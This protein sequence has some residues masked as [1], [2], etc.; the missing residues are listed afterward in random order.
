VTGVSSEPG[1]VTPPADLCPGFDSIAGPC[2]HGRGHPPILDSSGDS[3]AHATNTGVYWNDPEAADPGDVVRQIQRAAAADERGP[4]VPQ[5]GAETLPLLPADAPP[6]EVVASRDFALWRGGYYRRPPDFPTPRLAPAPLDAVREYLDHAPTPARVEL[7]QLA[8]AGVDRD[9]YA[10]A[11]NAAT[12]ATAPGHVLLSDRERIVRAALLEAA[13]RLRQAWQ[14]AD[15]TEAEH[16]QGLPT[17]ERDLMG[18]TLPGRDDLVRTRQEVTKASYGG[19]VHNGVALVA[20]GEDSDYWTAY[21]HHPLAQ[22]A[23]A[24]REYIGEDFVR[25]EDVRHVYAV[26]EHDDAFAED[27]GYTVRWR[28]VT[29]LDDRAFPLTFWS[30][31]EAA[32]REG[33]S[34]T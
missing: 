28:G 14:L 9:T 19:E 21:G 13:P 5:P 23:E 10:H 32:A 29:A 22:F 1:R 17:E 31:D 34:A 25:P 20:L 4:Y 26:M 12:R 27:D 11:F 30:A 33:P 2:V 16:P 24:C 6:G 3:W 18:H 7:D 15:A 8:A